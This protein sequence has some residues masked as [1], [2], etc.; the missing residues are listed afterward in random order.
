MIRYSDS[1]LKLLCTMLHAAVRGLNSLADLEVLQAFN[2][3]YFGNTVENRNPTLIEVLR[4]EEE[5]LRQKITW[6]EKYETV[7]SGWIT[8]KSA[9][10]K[11]NIFKNDQ[12]QNKFDDSETDKIVETDS[13]KN[14]VKI[15]EVN[16]KSVSPVVTEQDKPVA[17][18]ELI[19]EPA[20]SENEKV[21]PIMVKDNIKPDV[22][23]AEVKNPIIANEENKNPTTEQDESLTKESVLKD[24]VNEKDQ[25]T[26]SSVSQVQE[27]KTSVPIIVGNT[28]EMSEDGKTQNNEQGQLN[29][30]PE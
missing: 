26:Q 12:E 30:K 4:F 8:P 6:R 5:I 10:S 29:I 20:K 23:S 19:K 18:S 22:I 25:T 14:D 27:N 2:D 24:T 21:L 7:I 17:V 3:K 15:E 28:S 16:S 1:N 11:S 13:I 9:K